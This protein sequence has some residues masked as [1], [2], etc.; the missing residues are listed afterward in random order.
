MLPVSGAPQLIASG[1]ITGDHPVISATD[2]YSRLESPPSSWWKRFHSSRLRASAFSSSITGGSA[3]SSWPRAARHS[4]YTGSAGNTC[5]RM[6]SHI[7][8]QTSSARAER[9]KSMP[10]NVAADVTGVAPGCGR[11]GPSGIRWRAVPV[12][13]WGRRTTSR[14]AAGRRA[15]GASRATPKVA[16]GAS[17]SHPPTTTIARSDPG[18][19]RAR[20]A[21]VTGPLEQRGEGGSSRS[22]S[23]PSSCRTG[24]SSIAT[25]RG[26][27]GT[28]LGAVSAG[29]SVLPHPAASGRQPRTRRRP[30]PSGPAS[31]RWSVSVRLRL[32]DRGA[33]RQQGDDQ[34]DDR[35]QDVQHVVGGVD[36]EEVPVLADGQEAVDEGGAVADREQP[37]EGAS[38]RRGCA[39]GPGRRHRSGCARCCA[40]G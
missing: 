13:R 36:V 39:R 34:A 31:V 35:G 24:S 10:G 6:K 26:P 19:R 15:P 1:A 32:G 30:G 11:I 8:P 3:W 21:A 22:S 40:A 33:D 28:F 25:P 12:R 5:S 16:A 37:A 23:A 7:R 29:A 27:G 18:H 9:A 2:A 4:S 38:A 17:R 20:G 14:P